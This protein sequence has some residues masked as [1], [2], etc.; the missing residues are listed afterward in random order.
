M[1]WLGIVVWAMTLV[2][3]ARL[4]APT[5]A[6]RCFLSVCLLGQLAALVGMALHDARLVR[7]AHVT[8]TSAMVY[9]SVATRGFEL[10]AVAALCAFT[11]A[12][13]RALGYCMFAAAR[14]SRATD[15]PAY[16]L[17][18]AVPLAVALVRLG[19]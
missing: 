1:R 17:L 4:Y 18:Y 3:V 2:T 14:G 12:S 11:V 6:P 5:T 19:A 10:C 15:E 16:D 7:A 9:G 13:R 8:F